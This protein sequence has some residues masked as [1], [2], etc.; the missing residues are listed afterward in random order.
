MEQN[1]TAMPEKPLVTV[2]VMGVSGAGK[3]YVSAA[4]AAETGWTFLEGDSLHSAANRARM[5]AGLP[6]ND[7]ER[8]PWLTAVAGWIGD[9][10]AAGE[11]AVVSCS[12]LRRRYRDVLRAGHPSVWFVHLTVPTEELERRLLARTGHFM[13]ESLL[14]SQLA[15]LEPLQPDEPGTILTTDGDAEQLAAEILRRLAER[16]EAAR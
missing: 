8:A 5:H 9:R 6:L 1:L 16:R 15:T 3:S 14:A 7:A 11:N 4:L 10:E 12:A 2:V 13:P